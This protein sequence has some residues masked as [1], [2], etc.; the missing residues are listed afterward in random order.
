MFKVFYTFFAVLI[1]LNISISQAQVESKNGP[2][3]GMVYSLNKYENSLLAGTNMGVYRSTNNGKTWEKNHYLK[4]KT[5]RTIVNDGKNIYART[6]KD[7]Y[8]SA[9]DGV[10]W[11]EINKGIKS[12]NVYTMYSFNGEVY[13]AEKNAVYKFDLNSDTWNIAS[14]VLPEGEQI[15]SLCANNDFLFVITLSGNLYR[16]KK[17]ND[18][19]EKM[20]QGFYARYDNVF[21]VNGNG[22]YLACNKGLIRS[23][24]NFSTT[25]LVYSQSCNSVAVKDNFMI[26][27]SFGNGVSVSTDNGNTWNTAKTLNEK[28]YCALISEKTFFAG[29]WMG[30]IMASDNNGVNWYNSS[31]GMDAANLNKV[32]Y[33]DGKLF[34]SATGIGLLRSEN[35]G[36]DWIEINNGLKTSIINEIFIH[37]KKLMLGTNKG[38]YVS[39]NFGIVWE[40]VNKGLPD[41]FNVNTFLNY[42]DYLFIGGKGLYFIKGD[43]KEWIS[44]LGNLPKETEV[45]CFLQVDKKIIVGTKDGI[46]YSTN[47]G[48]FWEKVISDMKKYTEVRSIAKSNDF[49]LASTLSGIFSS[50]DLGK[51]WRIVKNSF[52]DY[53]EL[54]TFDNNL[55]YTKGLMHSV[56]NGRSW[57]SKGELF[58]EYL[59][60]YNEIVFVNSMIIIKDFAY[61]TITSGALYTIPTAVLFAQ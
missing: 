22:I 32:F 3:G 42:D 53:G 20:L 15:Q 11:I 60:E 18:A 33:Y 25:S 27:S 46:W 40:Q 41:N 23:S 59:D 16:V 38:I 50:P 1:L 58:K 5:V 48:K 8:I 49:L 4:N 45:L 39:P 21:Y 7:F 29:S 57:T 10:V 2:Y 26:T 55:I 6:L 24:D 9:N 56:D 47:L 31:R 43:S 28:Y 35:L 13:A 17:N 44:A 36:V 54:L 51:N 19:W 30:G 61:I 12:D 34:C 52:S 37:N 14:P